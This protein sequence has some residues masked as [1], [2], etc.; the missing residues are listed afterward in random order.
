[1]TWMHN[2]LENLQNIEKTCPAE[3]TVKQPKLKKKKKHYKSSLYSTSVSLLSWSLKEICSESLF[4]YTVLWEFKTL[5][6]F[7]SEQ[8][9]SLSPVKH[10]NFTRLLIIQT[11]QFPF[12]FV[13]QSQDSTIH[14]IPLTILTPAFGQL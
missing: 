1:M 13:V 7:F 8:F 3:V 11:M 4:S 14:L 5:E 12:P 9:H 6:A 10:C 2:H